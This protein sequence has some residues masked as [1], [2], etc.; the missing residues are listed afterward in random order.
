M[1]VLTHYENAGSRFGAWGQEPRLEIEIQL[2]PYWCFHR[3][4]TRCS[5]QLSVK[6]PTRAEKYTGIYRTINGTVTTPTIGGMK[7]TKEMKNESAF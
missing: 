4:V 6:T 5:K 7:L 1:P 3:H 2:R